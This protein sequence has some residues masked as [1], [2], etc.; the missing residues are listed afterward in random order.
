M[1]AGPFKPHSEVIIGC[2]IYGTL[3]IFLDRIRE[4]S[5]G[6]ILFYRLLFGFFVL[7]LYLSLSG[8]PGQLRPGKNRKYLILLAVLNTLTGLAYFTSI[9]LSGMSVAVLLLY[10][11]PVY[12]NF[13][14]PLVLG[15]KSGKNPLPL[16]LVL[17]GVL[18]VARPEKLIGDLGL[19]PG[20]N[21][22]SI[23]GLAAGL[24]SG[25]SFSGVILTVRYLKDDYTGFAK[26]FW[27]TGLG[28]IL[29]LPF[30]FITPLSVLF[31]NLGILLLL[32]LTATFAI[33]LHL[34]GF[35]GLRARTGSILAL[36]E[37]VFGIFFDHTV[38][39]SP[40]YTGTVLGCVFILAAA[41]LVSLESPFR[42]RSFSEKE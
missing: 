27:V 11:A 3:G 35:S 29:T 19:A 24:L 39:K 36:L 25:L 31:E 12:V 28:L 7:L 1:K 33:L 15:E 2:M 23:P 10:T 42:G 18:L 14:A 41:V 13:L 5:A 8:G 38:L 21:P 20:T 6:S 26:T 30:A 34:K 4:M 9:Q 40:L 17:A 37:P 22:V 16:F 32:A